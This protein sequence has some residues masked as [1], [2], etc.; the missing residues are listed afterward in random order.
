MNL[1]VDKEGPCPL[2]IMLLMPRLD[3]VRF[4]Q[5]LIN[6]QAYQPSVPFHRADPDDTDTNCWYKDR[7]Q[8]LNT[9]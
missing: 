1:C 4:N 5:G 7:T 3:S 6:P 8:H 2:F 9:C